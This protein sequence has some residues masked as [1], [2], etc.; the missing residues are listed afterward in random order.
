ML[1][2][3]QISHIQKTRFYQVFLNEYYEELTDR[4]IRYIR[5]FFI[6]SKNQEWWIGLARELQKDIELE[7]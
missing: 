3:F 1:K 7:K 5:S 2:V 4:S 6:M